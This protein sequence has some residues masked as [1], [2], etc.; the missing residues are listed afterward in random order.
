MRAHEIP[1]SLTSLKNHHWQL[2]P[3][4][5]LI[6]NS[7]PYKLMDSNLPLISDSSDGMFV[8][9]S[10]EHNAEPLCVSFAEC[11]Q[12]KIGL[13]YQLEYYGQGCVDLLLQHVKEHV[14]VAGGHDLSRGLYMN[15]YFPAVMDVQTVFDYLAK[16]E[17]VKFCD[18]DIRGLSCH[19][20]RYAVPNDVKANSK[21]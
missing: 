7:V 1:S 6:V 8:S 11:Y 9:Y 16:L 3:H 15:V 12:A 13:I 5:F 20:A 10:R 21:L 19:F 17:G 4:G 2:F 14:E 18:K